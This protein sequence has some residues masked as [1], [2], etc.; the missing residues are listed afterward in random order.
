MASGQHST[1]SKL[2]NLAA[3]YNY[4]NFFY[5]R[6]LIPS[7]SSQPPHPTIIKY[8]KTILTQLTYVSRSLGPL[9]D[10]LSMLR[11]MTTPTANYSRHI[12]LQLCWTKIAILYRLV[13]VY[14]KKHYD[15]DTIQSTYYRKMYFLWCFFFLNLY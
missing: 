12:I 5:F 15:S 7:C 2:I 9:E 3:T 8:I 10:I 13:V 4:D 11:T 14:G 6:Y 1:C